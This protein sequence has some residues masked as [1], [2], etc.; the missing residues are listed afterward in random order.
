M[1]IIL[2]TTTTQKELTLLEILAWI[3]YIISITEKD[4]EPFILGYVKDK[5]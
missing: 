4:R 2:T 5:G 3:K 1:L